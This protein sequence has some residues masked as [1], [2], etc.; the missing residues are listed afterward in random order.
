[1]NIFINQV[2]EGGLYL[3]EELDPKELDLETALIK[4][5]FPIK[6][7]AQISRITNALTVD[8]QITAVMFA[9]CSRCLEEFAWEFNKDVKLNYSLD[10][11]DTVIDLKP[12]IREE[13][14]LDYPIKLLCKISC[15]GL[16]TKCG[17][18]KNQGGCHCGST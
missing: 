2:P 11:R 4:F 13:I 9:G 15:K 8:L 5:R 7:A 16:C 12:E 1:M 17:K 6:L 3:K 18:N 14:I 10:N